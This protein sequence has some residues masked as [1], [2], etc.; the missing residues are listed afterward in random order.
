MRIRIQPQNTRPAQSIFMII[1]YWNQ[2]QFHDHL[3][4]DNSQPEALPSAGVE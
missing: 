1:L 3:V 2:A 4:L